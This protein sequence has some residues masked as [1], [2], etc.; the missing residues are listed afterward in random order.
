[1]F[2]RHFFLKEAIVHESKRARKEKQHTT[3][4]NKTT[5]HLL[6][7]SESRYDMDYFDVE[8][9]FLG[10]DESGSHGYRKK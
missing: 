8:K 2:N 9:Y 4:L 1:M 5:W 7:H 10:K 3:K 6:R